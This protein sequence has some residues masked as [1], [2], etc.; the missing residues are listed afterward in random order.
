ML[1]QFSLDYTQTE[2]GNKFKLPDVSFHGYNN[3]VKIFIYRSA[4][5]IPADICDFKESDTCK[6]YI[7]FKYDVKNNKTRTG[8]LM[9]YR[10]CELQMRIQK[11]VTLFNSENGL[12]RHKFCKFVFFKYSLGCT[13]PIVSTSIQPSFCTCLYCL[14]SAP[15]Y[16]TNVIC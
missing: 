3:H 5:S 6:C 16:F 1:D 15:S 9:L 12:P 4:Y 13:G 10:V 11:N 8:N 7:S 2:N 14:G